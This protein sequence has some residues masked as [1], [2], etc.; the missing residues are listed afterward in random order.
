MDLK[1]TPLNNS[2]N[3]VTEKIVVFTGA[4]VSAESGLKTFRDMGLRGTAATVMPHV[5]TCWLEGRKPL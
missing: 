5:A 3:C 4:G 2:E 1:N